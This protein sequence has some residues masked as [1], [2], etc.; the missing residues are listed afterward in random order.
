MRLTKSAL[1]GVLSLLVAHGTSAAITEQNWSYT[2]TEG[3]KLETAD[4]PRTDVSDVTS[5]T[6]DSFNRMTT[7]TNALGHVDSILEYDAAGR[8]TKSQDANGLQTH[9]TYTARGWLETVTIKAAAGDL[10]TTYT[11]DPVGQVINVAFPDSSTVAFEYD[12][13]RRLTAVEN[14]VG[15][16]IEYTLDAAGNVTEEKVFAADGTTLVRSINRSYDELSRLIDVDGNNGQNTSIAYD[17]NGNRVSATDGNQNTTGEARDA[18]GRVEAVTDAAN[19]T[20]QFT[21]DSAD[22]VTS[23][24]DQR[25]NTTNYEYD[26]AGH[27]IKLTSPDTGIA[28]YDYDE[29]GNLITRTD[30][31]GIVANYSYDAL[32]RLTGIVYPGNTSE[33]ASFTYDSTE[34]GNHGVGRLTGYSNDSGSTALAYDELGRVTTQ[35]DTIA[36]LSFN[37]GYSYDALGRVTEVTYPSGRIV[38]YVRD[39]LGRTTA[40]TSKDDA[41]ATAQTIVSNI[42]YQPYGGIASMEYGNGI[43]QTYTYD[44]DG[45]LQEVTAAGLGSVRSE[46]YTYDLANN[47]TGIADVLDANKDRVF[48]YDTLDRLDDEV[49]S[50]GSRDYQYDSVGNRTQRIWDKTDSTTSTATYAYEAESNRMVLRGSKAWVKD[51]AGNTVS[52]NDDDYLYTYNHANRMSSYTKSGVLKGTYS[53]NALGQRVRTDKSSD[54]LLH[55]N[56]SGQYLSE[57]TLRSDGV[58]LSNQ[59]DYIYLDGEPVAH[60]KTTYKS[61]GAVNK[62]F[63]TYLHTDHLYTPRVGTND[64]QAIVWRWDSDAF[65]NTNPLADVDGDGVNVT[66]NLRFPGQIK[67]GEAPFYYNYFRDYDPGTGRY[68]QSDRLGLI[69]G[70]NTFSYVKA[71]PVNMIDPS[72]EQAVSA[73]FGFLEGQMAKDLNLSKSAFRRPAASP[74]S[75]AQ[76][77]NLNAAKEWGY[78]LGLGALYTYVGGPPGY[79]YAA[80]SL[81]LVGTTAGYAACME[82]CNKEVCEK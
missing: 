57:T 51:A 76:A 1:A 2:Y 6:Y 68:L 44:L 11:Y 49:Y 75:C 48:A 18:L 31:R 53:Y 22:R 69:D 30:A 9:Y 52:H 71:N 67:G 29:A 66:V 13:A 4:G 82:E 61:S 39:S 45:R 58:S 12:A 19:N 81:G 38:T 78:G 79:A 74:L 33:N 42:Q 40:I 35:A 73:S 65:G 63:L 8:P 3:G 17:K 32:N 60:I 64:A 20:V 16:R 72:G 10:V 7:S 15:E 62:K 5:Y 59:V 80:G 77:C 41:Q 56:L 43:T 47:I 70:P 54:V 37:T 14:A 24:T 26:F 34:N 27:L 50:A 36:G 25:G 46:F 23:V 55:Y 28:D 21:Y